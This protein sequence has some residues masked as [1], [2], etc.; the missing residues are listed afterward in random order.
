MSLVANSFKLF[1][2]MLL[3]EHVQG[4][5]RDSIIMI[6]EYNQCRFFKISHYL[7]QFDENYLKV[8]E[9]SNSKKSVK[10]AS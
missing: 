8:K 10:Y 7:I 4:I 1:Y 9:E 6:R 2:H 5:S 3:C